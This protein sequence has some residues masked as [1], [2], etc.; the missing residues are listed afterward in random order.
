MRHIYRQRQLN[1]HTQLFKYDCRTH[2][3]TPNDIWSST[4]LGLG[5]IKGGG[6]FGLSPLPKGGPPGGGLLGNM[7]RPKKR[8]Y[9]TCGNLKITIKCVEVLQQTSR[10]HCTNFPIPY[11]KYIKSQKL[12]GFGDSFSNLSPR[13]TKSRIYWLF[14][15]HS[16]WYKLVMCLKNF[17]VVVKLTRGNS[18]LF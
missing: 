14:G 2:T 12:S 4:Y 7:P 1:R 8:V 11:T 13:V 6:P 3:V 16:N 18:L 5:D 9:L 10:Q 17:I 15:K